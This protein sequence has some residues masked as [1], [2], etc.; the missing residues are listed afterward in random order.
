MNAKILDPGAPASGRERVLDVADATESYDFL[1]LLVQ[2]THRLRRT[3]HLRAINGECVS[4]VHDDLGAPQP[5]Q[6]TGKRMFNVGHVAT[7][8][9]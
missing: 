3:F 4:A 1:R 8:G 6:K 2:S 9:T 7:D 5:T